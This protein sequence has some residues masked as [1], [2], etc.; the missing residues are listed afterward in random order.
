MK[1]S[2]DKIKKI[3]EQIINLLYLNAPKSL[4]TSHIAKELARDEEFIK[5]LLF[6]LKKKGIVV[7]VKKN[8][9]GKEYFRRKRWKLSD[10]VYNLI[11]SRDK[12]SNISF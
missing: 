7:E 3:S 10:R 12:N 2:E 1:L 4:F 6:D 11:L 5:K 8:P 9:K